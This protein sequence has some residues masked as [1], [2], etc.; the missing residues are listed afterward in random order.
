MPHTII[1]D[2]YLPIYEARHEL[3][4]YK[5]D[6]K[7]AQGKKIKYVDSKMDTSG[8]LSGGDKVTTPVYGRIGKDGSLWNPILEKAMAKHFGNYGHLIEGEAF[9]GVRLL[10]GSPFLKKNHNEGTTAM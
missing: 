2:D 5:P 6:K 7:D 10:T 1:V 8:K 3:L 4:A 9:D